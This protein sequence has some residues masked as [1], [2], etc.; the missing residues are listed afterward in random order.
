MT[1]R[2]FGECGGCSMLDVPYDVQLR[3]KTARLEDLLRGALGRRAPDVEP[4]RGTPASGPAGPLGFR[5]KVSFVFGQTARGRGLVMGHY[6]RGSQR[7]LPVDECP[8]HSGLGNRVA[9]AVRDALDRAAIPG[10]GPRLDGLAR[11]L[12]VRTTADQSGSVAMLVVTE[13]DKR[14]RAPV[15]KI[16]AGQNPPDGFVINVHDRPGPFMVGRHSLTVGGR[17]CVRETRLGLAFL[18]SPTAFF[19]TNVEAAAILL[20]EV[21]A[22][23]PDAP[24]TRVLDLYSGSG[25]FGLPLA[26]RGHA[27]TMIEENGQALKDAA[28][29]QRINAIAARRLRFVHARVEDALQR[30]APAG[31]DAA[32]LDPPRGG[33]GPAVIREVFER[34]RPSRTVYVSCDPE[35]LAAELPAIL[36]AG[37]R[38]TRVVPVDMFPHTDHI[39][40]VT[41][42]SR[43]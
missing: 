7:I 11:H 22:A 9:F 42:L 38:I 8:V 43:Q 4:M 25:L 2:H 28:A 16:L 30:L 39:E 5:H 13:N 3:R 31:A 6:A 18:I 35:A 20:D 19:Q 17:D 37:Y 29:N 33:C 21:L 26:A 15:K 23:V 40:T 27:V 24:G 12:I 34:V 1:C 32:V 36:A 41:V 14:L 10:A